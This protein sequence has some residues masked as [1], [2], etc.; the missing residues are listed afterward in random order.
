MA[1]LLPCC[2]DPL[3]PCLH[4]GPRV[5]TGPADFP[6]DG[7]PAVPGDIH[8]RDNGGAFIY[9]DDD[10][11]VSLGGSVSLRGSV[12]SFADLPYGAVAGDTYVTANT[13]WTYI[14]DGNGNWTHFTIAGVPGPTGPVGP[15]GDAR[16]GKDGDSVHI[17]GTIDATTKLPKAGH[18]TPGDI[19]IVGDVYNKQ[20]LDFFVG[21]TPPKPGDGIVF[22]DTG[23][24]E[25]IGPIRGPRGE[26]GRSP[27]IAFHMGNGLQGE[28]DHLYVTADA[29]AVAAGFPP[30]TA[31]PPHWYDI[32]VFG[33]KNVTVIGPPGQDGRSAPRTFIGLDIPGGGPAAHHL[34]IFPEQRQY[35]YDSVNNLLYVGDTGSPN[36]VYSPTGVAW[37][38]LGTDPVLHDGETFVAVEADPKT[39]RQYITQI[40]YGY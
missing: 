11:W 16:D 32:G 2:Q 10:R 29:D 13:G 3:V 7:L 22:Q 26:P 27:T 20:V 31:T 24:W 1:M 38:P 19:Y 34:G 5:T 18:E 36:S 35:G 39:H 25:N 4:R 17:V 8:L 40:Y 33:G 28:V 6:M 15:A 30:S 21:R 14:A 12:H 37:V 23:R 9:T